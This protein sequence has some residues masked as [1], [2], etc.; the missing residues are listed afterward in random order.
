MHVIYRWRNGSAASA[1]L[2]FPRFREYFENYLWLRPAAQWIRA[3]ELD[4]ARARTR[5]CL[6]TPLPINPQHSATF[7]L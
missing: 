6:R 3:Q 7:R 4:F 2:F 5:H 1:C